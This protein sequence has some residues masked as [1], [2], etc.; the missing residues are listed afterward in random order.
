MKASLRALLSGVID[1]AGLF[2]PAQLP[3]DVALANYLKYRESADAWMLGRFV[4]P[5]ARLTEIPEGVELTVSAIGRGGDTIDSFSAG[6]EANLVAIRASS[7]RVE[8]LEAKLPA[9]FTDY[10]LLGGAIE[11]ILPSVKAAGLSVFLEPPTLAKSKIQNVVDVL[12]EYDPP[13]P[14]GIKLRTGGLEAKAFP[15]SAQL[16]HAIHY[17]C[18]EGV[19]LKATAGLHHPFPRYDENL[20]ARMHGFVNVFAAGV[21]GRVCGLG[22]HDVRA[23]LE[24]EDPAR[25]RFED[26]ALYWGDLKATTEQIREARRDAVLSFGS[27][28]FDE[29][30]EDLRALG[31]M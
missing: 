14:L 19:R 8:V 5:A 17:A 23:I 30:R 13:K 22:E 16:A 20:Q 28:S 27:C 7:L 3:L 15:S 31:W 29:P 10:D 1:Y 25:F 2:P 4:C 12:A 18:R 11:E 26:D 9:G 6:I 24:E 21:L